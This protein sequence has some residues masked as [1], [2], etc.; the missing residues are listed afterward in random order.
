M[1]DRIMAHW[2]AVLPCPMLTVDY[3]TL[4]ADL[5][6]GS[7]RLIDFLGLPWEDRVLRFHETDRAVHTA[8]KWQVRQPV[9]TG[10]VGR[11]RRY[12][13]QLEPLRAVLAEA[14]LTDGPL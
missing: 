12:A 3:E 1:H 7:R 11:W 6:G 2:R 4:V 14:G 5:E 10:S 8:S 13:E 9:Y